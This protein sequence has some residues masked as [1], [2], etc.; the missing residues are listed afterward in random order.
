MRCPVFVEWC[1]VVLRCVALCCV[2]SH[3][4]V[5]C[6]VVWCCV[7]LRCVVLCCDMLC[8]LLCSFVVCFLFVRWLVLLCLSHFNCFVPVRTVTRDVFHDAKIRWKMTPAIVHRRDAKSD[9]RVYIEY[10]KVTV[11]ISQRNHDA[12]F[13]SRCKDCIAMQSLLRARRTGP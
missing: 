2:V 10:A 1:C 6:R 13:A 11:Q 12:K 8:F 5:A 4:V 9:L 7:V 3:R